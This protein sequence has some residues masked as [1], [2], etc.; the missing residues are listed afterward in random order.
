MKIG[1]NIREIR[2]FE[3]NLK[4]DYVAEQLNITTRAYANIENNIADITLDRLSEIAKIF[5]CNPLYILKYSRLKQDFYNTIHNNNGN[6][7]VINL[8][9]SQQKGSDLIYELQRELVESQRKRI[10]L[11]EALLRTNKI[12][13]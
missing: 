13:F 4:R 1:D 3:K 2:E 7:G 6:M 5:G 9:Q 11:L 8:N 12:D 10:D